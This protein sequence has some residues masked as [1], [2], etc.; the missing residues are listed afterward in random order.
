MMPIIMWLS[1]WLVAL[2]YFIITGI[3]F[4]NDSELT[5]D[6]FW[7]V[8]T[9]SFASLLTTLLRLGVKEKHG[10]LLLTTKQECIPSSDGS[11]FVFL[12]KFSSLWLS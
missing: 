11:L 6:K 2:E 9:A 7:L 4:D 3:K 1:S 8:I 10:N 12:I 5:P